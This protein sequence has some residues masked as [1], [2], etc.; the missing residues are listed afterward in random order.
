MLSFILA[1]FIAF[2]GLIAGTIIAIFTQEELPTGRKY[3]FLLQKLILAAIA[4]LFVNVFDIHIA[5]KVILYAIIIGLLAVGVPKSQFLYPA[6]GI[7][8]FFASK[9]SLFTIEALLIFL[10]GF[11]TGSLLFKKKGNKILGVLKIALQHISFVII[12]IALYVLTK[13][14]Y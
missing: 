7:I 4:V 3:F 11:P 8:L 12:A 6:L 9:S 14:I 5:L 13:S 2:L 10:Y 1:S